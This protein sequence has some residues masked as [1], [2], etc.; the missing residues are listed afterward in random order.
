MGNS[1]EALPKGKQ[2]SLEKTYQHRWWKSEFN[3]AHPTVAFLMQVL[4]RRCFKLEEVSEVAIQEQ[5]YDTDSELERIISDTPLRSVRYAR[6]AVAALL[7]DE[8][9]KSL[10]FAVHDVMTGED[11][12]DLANLLNGID[13]Q[14]TEVDT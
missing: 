8:G 9:G 7:H 1:F 4:N 10:R 3:D 2:S 12:I 14:L 6:L 13:S 11:R 5:L